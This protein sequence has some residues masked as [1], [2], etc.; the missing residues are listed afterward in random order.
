MPL[1]R[2][3]PRRR[4]ERLSPRAR[5]T[6]P[7]AGCPP[8]L[9]VPLLGFPLVSPH[10]LASHEQSVD[11][12]Q[13]VCWYE[14]PKVV[15]CCRVDSA[16]CPDVEDSSLRIR[17]HPSRTQRRDSTHSIGEMRRDYQFIWRIRSRMSTL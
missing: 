16:I 15:K 3:G 2:A 8:A 12:C 1:S 7:K 5:H 4:V 13:H 10:K 11:H 14:S 6:S 17:D 9:L